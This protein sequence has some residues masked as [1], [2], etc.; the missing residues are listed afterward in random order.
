MI[1]CTGCYLFS[2]LRVSLIANYAGI[3]VYTLHT[4]VR[5]IYR[6]ICVCCLYILGVSIK[7]RPI[8]NLQ[9]QSHEIFSKPIF[10]SIMKFVAL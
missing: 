9:E 6:R 4:F 7:L 5:T 10:S 1:I 8:C 3:Y 2:Y